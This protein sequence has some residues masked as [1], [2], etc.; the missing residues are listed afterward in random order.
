MTNGL[1][2]T[3]TDTEIGK[4]YITALIIKSLRQQHIKAGYF[5]AA[6]SGAEQGLNDAAYVIKTCGLQGKPETYVPFIYREAVS[7]HLAAK[8]EDKALKKGQVEIVWQQLTAKYDCLIA[9]GSG[10][11]ICPLRYDDKAKI[12]LTDIIK[13]T[14]LPIAITVPCRVGAIN[15]AALSAAYAQNLGLETAGFILNGYED[16]NIVHQDN[17]FMIQELTGLPILLKI[18][19]NAKDIPYGDLKKLKLGI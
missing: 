8:L 13:M 2:I 14:G 6:L 7:P 17:A 1:F 12:M 19:P 10:G 16:N 4:T 11:L 9:E 5:K 18:P 3:G 15:A